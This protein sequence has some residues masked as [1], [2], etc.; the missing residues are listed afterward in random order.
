M[1]TQRRMAEYGT[2]QEHYGYL[3]VNARRWAAMNDRALFREPLTLEDY[4]ASRIVVDPL[5]LLDCD[6]P[7]NGASAVVITSPAR[8]R[9]LRNTPVMIESLAYGTGRNPDWMFEDDQV[10]GA[11]IDC[12]RTLWSR[13][14][15]RPDGIDCAQLYDGFTHITLSWI[16]ALGFCALG[17]YGDWVAE[18]KTIGPGGSLPLNTAGG[19]LGEGRL[20]GLTLFIE[21]V[22]QLRGQ[23]GLRQVPGART[24]V[25]ANSYG[26]QVGAMT[27][28]TA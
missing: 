17:E 15:L 7:V 25:V 23:A 5:L 20:H 8:A 27:L 12:G 3:A 14:D 28:T 21:A 16:E 2:T 6:R 13:S 9:D 10:F 18:G 1:R 4:L 19:H 22:L 24:S 11:T 26:P